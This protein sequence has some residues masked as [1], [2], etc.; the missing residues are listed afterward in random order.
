MRTRLQNQDI[1]RLDRESLLHNRDTRD[2]RLDLGHTRFEQPDARFDG[3]RSRLY[4]SGLLPIAKDSPKHKCRDSCHRGSNDYL[5]NLK[6]RHAQNGPPGGI[7]GGGSAGARC[8]C[9]AGTG[10]FGSGGLGCSSCF[11]LMAMTI[12]VR[13]AVFANAYQI[14]N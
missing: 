13:M 4:R 14:Q 7:S 10:F 3:N 12:S 5:P 9:G 1:R 2:G 8:G 6:I 11:L